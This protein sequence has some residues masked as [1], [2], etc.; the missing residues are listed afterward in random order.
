M[1]RHVEAT[2]ACVL[3]GVFL[4]HGGH[5][6]TSAEQERKRAMAFDHKFYVPILKAK[7]GELKALK[8]AAP[9]VRAGCAPLLEIT[10]VA[11]KKCARK[12][13]VGGGREWRAVG[14]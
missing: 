12:E 10:D 6:S 11:P 1:Q 4:W 7:A 13:C 8:E 9:D 14:T 3:A 2:S 5:C